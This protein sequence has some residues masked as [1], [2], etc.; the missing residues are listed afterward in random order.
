MY[1]YRPVT[2]EVLTCVCDRC[3]REMEG[4]GSGGDGEWDERFTISFRGGYHSIFGDGNLIEGDFCQHCIK[5]LLGRYLRITQDDP[6]DP[7]HKLIAAEH[8]VYQGNAQ[9]NTIQQQNTL[10][11]QVR[12]VLQEKF[13]LP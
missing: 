10:T 2:T 8:R 13:K 5:D 9:L 7:K 11:E 12:E 4:S 6:F 1:V 3:G